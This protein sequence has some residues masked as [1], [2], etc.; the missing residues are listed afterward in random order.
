MWLLPLLSSDRM[1]QAAASISTHHYPHQ[2]GGGVALQVSQGEESQGT[3]IVASEA[4]EV[5]EEKASSRAGA[6]IASELTPEQLRDLQQLQDRDREVRAHEAAH[7]AA[8]AGL[9]RGGMSF[10]YQNGPDG[11]R[12]AVGGEVSIDSS[13]VADDPQATLEKARQIQAAALAPAEPSAQDRA[14][15][16]LA[17]RMALDARIG[18]VQLSRELADNSPV[19]ERTRSALDAYRG[20]DPMQQASVL[21]QTV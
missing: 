2:G 14:V 8:A 12:Y 7:M 1:I 17:A 15:A 13:P 6:G 21:D 9:V 11:R 20:E 18:L 16:A 10:S 5:K 3:A 4:N 19:K